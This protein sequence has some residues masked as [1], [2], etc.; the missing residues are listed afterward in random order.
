METG[1]QLGGRPWV[2]GYR[3]KHTLMV[4]FALG[5][6]YRRSVAESASR[7]GPLRPALTLPQKPPRSLSKTRGGFC[8]ILFGPEPHQAPA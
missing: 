6:S 3:L 1:A 7:L 2:R 8:C 5:S 4:A